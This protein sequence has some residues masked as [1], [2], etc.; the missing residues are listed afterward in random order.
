MLKSDVVKNGLGAL[1]SSIKKE[2]AMDN[3]LTVVDLG[4][5]TFKVHLTPKTGR[6]RTRKTVVEIFEVY[7]RSERFKEQSE[8]LRK[9]EAGYFR[10]H[11]IPFMGKLFSVDV[12]SVMQSYVVHREK[13]GAK[14]NTLTLETRAL[15]KALVEDNPAWRKPRMRYSN[16]PKRTNLSFSVKDLLPVIEE[17]KR[18]SSRYGLEYFKVGLVA[19]FTS[20]RLKDV[21]DL[22]N[23]S[24]DR[25]NWKI[26]FIQS[27]VKNILKAQKSFRTSEP[28]V[29]DVC[30]KLKNIFGQI[31]ETKKGKLFDVPST[32]AVTTA[33]LRAF[34][35]AGISGSF[36]T[37][38]HACATTM[39]ANGANVKVVQD[40]L[41]HANITTT[42]KYL[43]AMDKDK[44]NA[45]HSLEG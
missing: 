43:H 4:G 37:F 44:K 41:G 17:V 39:L 23:D 29:I 5:Q 16:E 6:P 42:M 3:N 1:L 12:A 20:M 33:F 22:T 40:I 34:K 15:S 11:I 14:P 30:D 18:S 9:T 19:A 27:K 7:K 28:V 32:K 24:L 13:S 2:E 35:S 10:L 45:I 38:R 8:G 26:T 21:V 25:R 36:H 31:P